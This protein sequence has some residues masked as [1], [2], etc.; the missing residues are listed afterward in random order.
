MFDV[1]LT[2]VDRVFSSQA[3]RHMAREREMLTISLGSNREEGIARRV[4]MDFDQ[5]HATALQQSDSR[6]TVLGGSYA[7][8]CAKYSS[9]RM[10]MRRQGIHDPVSPSAAASFSVL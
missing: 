2:R 9:E 5:V 6:P 10:V 4:V 3:T 1:A 8:P 7:Q